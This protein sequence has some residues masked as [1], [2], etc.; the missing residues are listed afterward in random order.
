MKVRRIDR[1]IKVVNFNKIKTAKIFSRINK[2]E[3]YNSLLEFLNLLN[4]KNIKFSVVCYSENKEEL[5]GFI[6]SVDLFSKDFIFVSDQDIGFFGKK[7]NDLANYLAEFCDVF[8]DLCMED[9]FAA[10]YI[11][12]LINAG[13]KVGS[14]TRKSKFHDLFIDIKNNRDIKYLSQQIEHYLTMIKPA[15]T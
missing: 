15:K 2:A 10:D 7:E 13:F 14:F 11:A 3:D 6:R 8:I 12:G 4:T 1:Q 9:S 5:S